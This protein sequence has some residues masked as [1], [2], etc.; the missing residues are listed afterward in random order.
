[1]LSLDIALTRH[2]RGEIQPHLTC[3]NHQTTQQSAAQEV[4]YKLLL[5]LFLVV[6]AVEVHM[7]GGNTYP[8]SCK[9]I[10]A[11]SKVVKAGDAA[12]S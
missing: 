1:M 8:S 2:V 4:C 7:H 9:G 10:I 5:Q 3:A 11:G 12:K 6:Q